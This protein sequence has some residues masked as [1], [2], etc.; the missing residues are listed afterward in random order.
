MFRL[1]ALQVGGYWSTVLELASEREA[2]NAM[3][4][5]IERNPRGRYRIA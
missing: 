2:I 1:Q 5:R 4:K 3:Q